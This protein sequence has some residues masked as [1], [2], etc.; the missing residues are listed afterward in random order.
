MDEQVHK[1]L[2]QIR[3]DWLMFPE[4]SLEDQ[5]WLVEELENALEEI[6]TL[7][8]IMEER[9]YGDDM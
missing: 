1:R 3:D 7:N 4:V 8:V 9:E 5:L 2:Q 6:D